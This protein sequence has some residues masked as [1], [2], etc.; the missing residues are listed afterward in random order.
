MKRAAAERGACHQLYQN[1]NLGSRAHRNSQAVAGLLAWEL[2]RPGNDALLQMCSELATTN[3][4]RA[5]W[6]PLQ[7]LQISKYHTGESSKD[8]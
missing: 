8:M 4:N 3:S 6:Q 5:H 7:K 1:W 2:E